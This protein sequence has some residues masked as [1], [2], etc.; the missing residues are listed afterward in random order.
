MNISDGKFSDLD[1]RVL[2]EP[3][4][5]LL[6]AP[7]SFVS[8]EFS[9]EA[10]MGFKT[11]LASIPTPARPFFSR[12][13]PSRKPAAAHDHMYTVR[14][15]TREVCDKIFRDMLIVQGVSEEEANIFYAAVRLGGWT[16]GD[17]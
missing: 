7:M 2:D 6:L 4:Q 11:D 5:F 9:Y 1:L 13:G 3:D 8:K 17:W 12:N 10:P 15:Q 14:F 16:R